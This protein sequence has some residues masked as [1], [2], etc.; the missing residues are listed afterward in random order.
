[1]NMRAPVGFAVAMTALVC[2]GVAAAGPSAAALLGYA[3]SHE[4][5]DATAVGYGLGL[6]A[7]A[8][9]SLPFNLYVGGTFVYHLGTDRNDVTSN[10]MYGGG[11]AG[12]DFGEGRVTIRPYLGFG[13]ANWRYESCGQIQC[14][15]GVRNE[16][17]FALW[18]G[19]AVLVH[20]DSQILVGVDLRYFALLKE[21]GENAPSAFLTVGASF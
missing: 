16:G 19:A 15:P 14:G 8:G 9:W 3:P 12:Y 17:M 5:D 11:E 7:R 21:Y 6:G 20:V 4:F 2:S 18:P 13:Y 1:M 10:I